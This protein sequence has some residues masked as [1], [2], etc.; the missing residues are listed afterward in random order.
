LSQLAKE[1]AAGR[2]YRLPTEAEWEYACR[3]ATKTRY[4]TGD[5]EDDLKI[6][7]W[8]D[9]NSD[10][11]THTV[12]SKKANAW[13]LYDMHGN[14]YQWC[15]DWYDKDYYSKGDNKDPEGPK[16]GDSRVLRGGCWG[17][18]ARDCRS[19]D[20]ND[21]DPGDGYINIGFRVVCAAPRTR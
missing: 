12:G 9:G 5:D 21:F 10:I 14:V 15:Y 6:A 18:I 16:S 7:G 4:Y 20:R 17:G 19:A 2:E 1:K 3:A 11:R 13:G 8:Y